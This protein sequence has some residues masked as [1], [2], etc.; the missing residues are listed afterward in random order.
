VTS[1][2]VETLLG[3]AQPL[4]LAQPLSHALPLGADAQ[5]TPR[6]HHAQIAPGQLL[7]V[8][9]ETA[10]RWLERGKTQLSDLID[11]IRHERRHGP[12]Q[13]ARRL[14][15]RL[16]PDVATAARDFT[17]LAVERRMIEQKKPR[18]KRKA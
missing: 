16:S 4:G 12:E 1:K 5:L 6:L 8:L 17:V 10:C 9:G 15:E 11:M 13:L 18:G 2:Q 7:V 14:G 3:P